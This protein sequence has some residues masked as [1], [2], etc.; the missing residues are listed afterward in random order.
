[1][2]TSWLSIAEN[3]PQINGN[4]WLPFRDA[5]SEGG[6]WAEFN[7]DETKMVLGVKKERCDFIRS[8][9]YGQ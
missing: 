7:A 8:E 4:E 6:Y 2:S 3:N 5:F 9:W 1:M